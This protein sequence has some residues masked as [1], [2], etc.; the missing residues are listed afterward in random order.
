MKNKS[1]FQYCYDRFTLSSTPL[2]KFIL[3]I[4]FLSIFGCANTV[5]PVPSVVTESIDPEPFEV[6]E[7]VELKSANSSK[8]RKNTKQHSVGGGYYLDDGPGDNPPNNL[9]LIPNAI[10]KLE[11]LRKANMHPYKVM[12]KTFEPMTMLEPYKE[13]GTAS[14]YGRRYHGNPTAS[15]EIYDMYAMTAAHPTL[16]LPSYARVTSVDSGKTV[17]VRVNDRGPFLSDRLIDLSYTAAY[18]LDFIE[19]GSGEVIIESILPEEISQ[20]KSLQPVFNN[21]V[22]KTYVQLGAFGAV[23]NAYEYLSVINKKLPELSSTIG[24]VE[25][26]GLFKIYAGPYDDHISAQEA[27]HTITQKLDIDPLI[28]TDSGE[29]RNLMSH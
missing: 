8:P 27:A 22:D 7:S 14:W 18:K 24:V 3:S 28:V 29:Y 5:K 20:F 21:S 6:I 25:Q 26:N 19:N 15:G 2:F 11:P 16:P 4:T 23:V 17:I 13:S 10:P 1:M 12:G 9:H